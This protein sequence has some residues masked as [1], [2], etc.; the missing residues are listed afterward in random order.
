MCFLVVLVLVAP[1]Q[2]VIVFQKGQDEPIRGIL[3]EETATHIVVNEVL[4]S[5]GIKKWILTRAQIDDIIRAVSADELAAL[6]HDNAGGYRR[7]AEDLAA[8]TEDPEARGMAIRLYVIAAYLAPEQL[9]RSCLLGAAG[10]ARTPEEERAFRAMAFVL[11]PDHDATLLKAMKLV[12]PNF[13]TLSKKQRLEL[14]SAVR[15]LRS[16]KF[17]SAQRMFSRETVQKSMTFYNDIASHADYEAAIEAKGRLPAPLLSKFITLEIAL[18][19]K[20]N[21]GGQSGVKEAVPWSQLIARRATNAVKPLAL[22]AITEFD[23][24]TCHFVDGKWMEPDIAE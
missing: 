5:G 10:L 7:Y 15:M 8:K 2:A 17:A 12:A 19:D 9:G 4:P 3:V 21:S 18:G 16:G 23:P 22:E 13:S 20:S 24:R 14:R 6:R 1:C 11:D